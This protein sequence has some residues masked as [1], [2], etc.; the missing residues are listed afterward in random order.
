M[1]VILFIVLTGRINCLFASSACE[2]STVLDLL[3][4]DRRIIDRLFY[5]SRLQMVVDQVSLI[6]ELPV[7]SIWEQF[8]CPMLR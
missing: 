2:I 6:Q 5:E 4:V 3:A 7:G 8:D 1:L